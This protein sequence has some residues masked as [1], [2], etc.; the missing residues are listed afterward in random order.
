MSVRHRKQNSQAHQHQE[1]DQWR[2]ALNLFGN[3]AV[4][5]LSALACAA[6]AWATPVLR[7][8]PMSL[9]Q[10]LA[11]P[12][13][14]EL[15]EDD[16][17]A[18]AGVWPLFY[19]TVRDDPQLNADF[20]AALEVYGRHNLREALTFSLTKRIEFE[21]AD[22]PGNSSVAGLESAVADYRAVYPAFASC[23][24]LQQ[25]FDT[26]PAFKASLRA[27]AV[28][29]GTKKGNDASARAATRLGNA[30]DTFFQIGRAS[31]RERVSSPV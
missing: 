6:A 23:E 16:T 13:P 7:M 31:C 8:A 5:A 26:V 18:I 15:L 30:I 27:A 10:S 1:Q 17:E 21:L 11:L 12:S 2:P 29:L 25:P 19:A 24:D 22:Q 28:S 14:Y 4:P 20:Q 9:L 3:H